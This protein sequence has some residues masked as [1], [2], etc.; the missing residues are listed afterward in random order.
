MMSQDW[1]IKDQYRD[2]SRD[3]V[4]QNETIT[5]FGDRLVALAERNILERGGAKKIVKGRAVYRIATETPANVEPLVD[6]QKQYAHLRSELGVW[7]KA[8]I[9][10]GHDAEERARA[11]YLAICLG[12]APELKQQYPEQWAQAAEAL[13]GYPKVL[14]VIFYEAPFPAGDTI[15][16]KAIAAGVRKPPTSV[17]IWT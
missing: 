14:Q 5:S 8:G 11:A 12:L 9:T 10:A 17:K 3:D 7:V 6:P 2:T 13:N 4:P 15:R 1:S 16:Q